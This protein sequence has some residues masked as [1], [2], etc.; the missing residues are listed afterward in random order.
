MKKLLALILAA[1][2]LL[3][4]A[5]FA[6]DFEVSQDYSDIPIEKTGDYDAS[7]DPAAELIF[8]SV[9]VT[10][11]SHTTAMSA[12]AD[13]VKE[14]SGG[15]VECKTYADGTLFSSE[16][17]WDAIS[18]GQA[19]LAYISFPTLSTQDG[20]EWCAMVNSGYFW[21]SYEHMTSTLNDSEVGEKIFA[22][23]E[24][25]TNVVPLGAYYLGS[26]VINTRAKEI[27]SYDDMAGL[28]LRMPGSEAWQNLGAALGA[29]PTP[30]SF[31]E[32]YTALSTGAVD[33]QDNPLPSDISAKFYEVAPYIAITN[34]VVDSIIPCINKDKWNSLTDA[35]KAAVEDAIA[36]AA[37]VNDTL[38][39]AS[40]EAAIAYLEGK[41]CTVTYP[42]LPDFI[43]HVQQYYADHPEQTETWNMELYEEIQALAK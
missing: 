35:Q 34:H 39:I 2:M 23:I 11:D 14:L 20:L 13:A 8:T 38:R 43:A 25:K 15:S 3:S 32:L 37:T 40:E 19:D 18:S 28:L 30:L 31:S 33:A 29:N 24:E 27:N 41:G 16:V 10:G 26:R 9:S 5:A 1:L 22:E 21:A 42:D 7:G 6:E 36:Y 12:F 17:E 4:C